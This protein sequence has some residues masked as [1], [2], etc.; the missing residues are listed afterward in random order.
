MSIA[1]VVL[2]AVAA[3]GAYFSEEQAWAGCPRAIAAYWMLNET[4]GSIFSDIIG[5]SNASCSGT[6]CPSFSSGKMGGALDFNGSHGLSVTNVTPFNWGA[7]N[8]FSVE[9][10]MKSD[11][12]G[13]CHG[14]QVLV[15]RSGQGGPTWLIECGDGGKAAFALS[16]STG[17]SALITGTSTISDGNWH[18]V[19]AVRDASGGTI[20]L[21]VDSA[22]QAQAQATFT[23]NFQSQTPLTIG[24]INQQP[25]YGFQGKIDDVAVYDTAIPASEVLGHYYIV[26]RY[27]DMCSSPVNI[28]PLGDSITEGSNSGVTPDAPDYYIAYRKTL[29]DLL[30]QGGFNTHFVGSLQNGQAIFSDYNHEGHPGFTA[31]PETDDCNGLPGYPNGGSNCDIEDNITTYLS[32]QQAGGTPPEVILLHIGT[33]WGD[34]YETAPTPVTGSNGIL[35]R[36]YSFDPDM[37]V[38]LAKIILPATLNG[39][40]NYYPYQANVR[41]F[42]QNVMGMAENDWNVPAG[43]LSLLSPTEAAVSNG[44]YKLMIVDQQDALDYNCDSNFDNCDMFGKLHPAPTGYAKMANVWFNAMKT[45]LP[46]C[47]QTISSAP[48]FHDFGAQGTGVSSQ[49]QTFTITDQGN[50][51]LIIDSVSLTGA[52]AGQF[53]VSSDNCSGQTVQPSGSCTVNASF[54]PNATGPIAALLAITSN[55]PAAP[56]LSIQLSGNGVLS[57]VGTLAPVSYDFGSAT[58]GVISTELFT[59]TNQGSSG[60]V[61]STVSISGANPTQ[62]AIQSDGCTGKSLSSS[63]SCQVTVVFA[64]TAAQSDTAQL[65]FATNSSVT[66]A[67]TATLNGAGLSNATSNPPTKPGL[68]SP[69]ENQAGLDTTVT[70]WWTPSSDPAGESMSYKLYVSQNKD[71]SNCT[72][73]DV[74]ESGQKHSLPFADAAG[75]AISVM[76]FGISRRKRLALLLVI[77]SLSIGLAS[78]GGGGGSNG[79]NPGGGNTNISSTVQGLQSGTTY[80]WKVAANNVTGQSA[81]SDTWTFGTR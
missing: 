26:R 58:E 11:S 43:S 9:L 33:N 63:G 75:L 5:G 65:S 51:P 72:P 56:T 12:P 7:P 29:K 44:P 6:A 48:F 8:S 57:P 39:Q 30:V 24:W 3:S 67:L 77:M 38:L 21:Y 70:F 20:S 35:D 66:A 59:L 53:A 27:C 13:T 32:T 16:D 64:P 80:F 25:S 36:I 54:T 4:S 50:S 37:T 73:I 81:E 45:F 46:Y 41:Q 49:P 71:F 42:N 74:P 47:G 60:L 68:V 78:C 22:L 17:S 14:G 15:G 1:T 62:F 18:H 40:D 10:W 76:A 61:V 23:G 52:D 55:D 19:T 28:M 69:G 2:L 79:G 31:G 34:S